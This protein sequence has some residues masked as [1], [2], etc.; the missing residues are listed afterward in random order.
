MYLPLH[1]TVEER[2]GTTL[3]AMVRGVLQSRGDEQ[4]RHHRE[5]EGQMLTV[6]VTVSVPDERISGQSAGR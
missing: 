2:V 1:L 3:Q 5:R 4:T 6:L